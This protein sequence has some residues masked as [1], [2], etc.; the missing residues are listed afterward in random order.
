MYFVRYTKRKALLPRKELDVS[1]TLSKQF[2]FSWRDQIMCLKIVS[3]PFSQIGESLG[4]REYL[5]LQRPLIVKY[6]KIHLAAINSKLPFSLANQHFIFAHKSQHPLELSKVLVLLH[7]CHTWLM[8][9][10]WR[11]S[12]WNSHGGFL[13]RPF[14]WLWNR[15]WFLG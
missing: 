9:H 3:W 5:H 14:I 13:H 15:K 8:S 6:F 7:Q 10:Q 12:S 4:A 1:E 2:C 11:N